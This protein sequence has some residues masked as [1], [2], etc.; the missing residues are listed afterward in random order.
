MQ[1]AGQRQRQR[2]RRAGVSAA[3]PEPSVLASAVAVEDASASASATSSTVEFGTTAAT[4]TRVFG[5]NKAHPVA[6]K[7]NKSRSSALPHRANATEVEAAGPTPLVSDW[8]APVALPTLTVTEVV[9]LVPIDG[10]YIDQAQLASAYHPRSF[11]SGALSRAPAALPTSHSASA[12]A[13]PTAAGR[14]ST[15][16]GASAVPTASGSLP[17]LSHLPVAGALDGADD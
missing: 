4:T 6:G 14:R 8:L 11:A 5:L 7:W 13:I 15:A 9:T 3:A 16:T 2:V 1:A 10:H 12:S 17:G